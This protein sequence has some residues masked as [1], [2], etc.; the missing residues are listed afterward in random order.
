[1]KKLQGPFSQK[2]NT[3]QVRKRNL[4]QRIVIQA[5][6][7]NIDFGDSITHFS[8]HGYNFLIQPIYQNLEN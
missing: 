7:H 2:L 5:A 3:A 1:M 4:L 6:L 8:C